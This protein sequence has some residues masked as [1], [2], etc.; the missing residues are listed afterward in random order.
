MSIVENA[1]GRAVLELRDPATIRRRCGRIFRAAVE[2]QGRFAV[3]L[4]RLRHTCDFVLQTTR[5]EYPNLNIP[6]HSRWRHFDAG[7]K[8]R[9]PRIAAGLRAADVAE[10]ARCRFDLAIVSVLLDAGAGA[11]WS[12]EDAFTNRRFARSEGLAVAS[13]DL[14]ESGAFSSNPGNPFQVDADGLAALDA[15]RLA[16]GF[17]V[18]PDNP[19]VGLDGRLDLLRRLGAALRANAAMFPGS[20]PR[21]GHLYDYLVSSAPDG[22]G[23]ADVLGAVL[24]GFAEV[25]PSRIRLGGENL[26]DVWRHAA[27][28]GR[29]AGSG[30]V[31]FHKLSQ[32]LSYSLVEPLQEA[33]VEVKHLDAMTGLPEYRN[34]GLLLDMGVLHPKDPQDLNKPH[35]VDSALIV[36]WRALTVILLDRI[37]QRIRDILGRDSQTLPLVCIL[38]GGTWTAGRKIARELRPGGGPPLCIVSDG[39]VF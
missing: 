29:G 27:A 12:Y 23:A 30:L 18:A 6:F 4:K 36:E 33:G 11:H 2:G 25:W 32:W 26:G 19:L 13:F 38:Q 15:E 35:G 21:P 20:P 14:F 39:T 1:E 9:W 22:L 31:P 37:A 28:G 24:I 17:Q 16:A 7:G 8:A 10:R 34:G 5:D 3:D